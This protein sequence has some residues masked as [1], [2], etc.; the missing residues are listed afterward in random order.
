M[1]CTGTNLVAV[2]IGVKNFRDSDRSSIDLAGGAKAKIDDGFV[3][4]RRGFYVKAVFMEIP[5]S[6][7]TPSLSAEVGYRSLG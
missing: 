5:K 6:R 4:T 1:F 3:S 2:K 7:S